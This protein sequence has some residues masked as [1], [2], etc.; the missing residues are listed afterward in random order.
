MQTNPFQKRAGPRC[1]PKLSFTNVLSPFLSQKA[2]S[3]TVGGLHVVTVGVV[4]FLVMRSTKKKLSQTMRKYIEMPWCIN[5][6]AEICILL[7]GV[8]KEILLLK[9]ILNILQYQG[10][11]Q[12]QILNEMPRKQFSN[13]LM[14]HVSVCIVINIQFGKM[15][16]KEDLTK[17]G[18]S[19]TLIVNQSCTF[20]CF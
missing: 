17:F 4:L 14:V 8:K 11:L 7:R 10:R 3:L 16:E 12:R 15:N 9:K 6:N 5:N 18:M 1:A 20:F 13:W 2:S 19:T